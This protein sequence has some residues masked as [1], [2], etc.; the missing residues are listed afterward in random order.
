MGYLKHSCYSFIVNREC[1]DIGGA[2]QEAAE[3]S[4]DICPTREMAEGTAEGKSTLNACETCKILDCGMGIQ[5]L[6]VEKSTYNTKQQ[7]FKCM[8][9]EL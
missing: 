8:M 6:A 1:T 5:S 9:H 2:P 3:A 4:G 7:I